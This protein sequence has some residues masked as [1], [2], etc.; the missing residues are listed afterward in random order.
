MIKFDQIQINNQFD[1][2]DSDQVCLIMIQIHHR[3]TVW[4]DD[5]LH[6]PLQ[7]SPM[8]LLAAAGKEEM[9]SFLAVPLLITYL[10]CNL[11]VA[12]RITTIETLDF[13]KL[14]L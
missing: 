10:V 1:L 3:L 13:D 12:H 11:A 14:E 9:C 8:N 2:I 5:R 7:H 4:S 6:K